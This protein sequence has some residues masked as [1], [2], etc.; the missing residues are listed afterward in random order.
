MARRRSHHGRTL[1]TI[2]DAKQDYIKAIETAKKYEYYVKSMAH[3]FGVG[4]D[5]IKESNPWKHWK[6]FADKVTEYANVWEE[7][8]KTAFGL[9]AS[10]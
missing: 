2:A 8:L 4:E 10:S 3:F 9:T 5:R 6:E 7:R 1:K